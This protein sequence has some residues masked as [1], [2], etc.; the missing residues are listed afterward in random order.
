MSETQDVKK[1]IEEGPP[2]FM[3]SLLSPREF[4]ENRKRYKTCHLEAQRPLSDF[5]PGE[6]KCR[7]RMGGNLTTEEVVGINKTIDYLIENYVDENV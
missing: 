5:K 4:K 1:K 6:F 2:L 3:E 7:W